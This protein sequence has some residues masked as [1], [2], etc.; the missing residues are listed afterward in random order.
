MA[1][2]TTPRETYFGRGCLDALKTIEGKKALV[3]IGGGSVKRSGVL[4][5]AL[6]YLKEAGIETQVFEGVEADPS[7]ETVTKGADVMRAFEPDLIIPIGGGSPIDAAKTMWL[8]Y[9][10]PDAD[11]KNINPFN[12]PKLR[13]KAKMVA[14]PTTS[15]TASEVTNASV[16]CDYATGFKFGVAGD[17]IIPD[18]A[19]LDPDVASTMTDSLIAFTGLDALTHSIESYV[20]KFANPFTDANAFHAFK[21]V[22]ANLEKAYARD[23]EAM[24][25]MHYAQCLAGIAFCSA[26]L[27]I[28]HSMAHSTGAI[29]EFGHIP[30]GQANSIYMPYVIQ[31]NIQDARAKSRY[32]ELAVAAGV[33]GANEDEL[34][35]GLIEKIR[36]LRKALGIPNSLNEFEIPEEEFNEKLDSI[37]TNAINDSLTM[38]NPRPIDHDTFKKVLTYMYE[39]K[40][41]DF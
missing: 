21:L 40:D 7:I 30:H 32:A 37:A 1:R 22:I 23:E 20:S 38:S 3:I 26:M 25:T 16:I 15:G 10:H 27:G 6:E 31:Y 5:K 12:I 34:I 33:S 11:I 18:I 13:N 29:F 28:N 9:E 8:L 17:E 41:I 36:G 24:E 35:A 39:G 14:V 4:D 19:I 2:F